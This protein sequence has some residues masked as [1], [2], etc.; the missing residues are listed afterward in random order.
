[1]PFLVAMQMRWVLMKN[2]NPS[3][4]EVTYSVGVQ[5][6]CTIQS[7]RLIRIHHRRLKPALIFTVKV[8]RLATSMCNFSNGT[9]DSVTLGSQSDEIDL[10]LSSSLS[11]PLFL[12]VVFLQWALRIP[13]VSQL[14]PWTRISQCW[15]AMRERRPFYDRGNNWAELIMVP[16]W[17]FLLDWCNLE[18]RCIAG[19]GTNIQKYKPN[20]ASARYTAVGASESSSISCAPCFKRSHPG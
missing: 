19:V 17:L 20:S 5:W 4:L 12:S 7:I 3:L 11:L 1:M 13:H 10:P 2:I 8:E 18:R 14:Q 9:R 15:L 6:I 16:P